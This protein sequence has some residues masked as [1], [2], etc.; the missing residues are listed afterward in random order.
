M[1]A[2]WKAAV[3]AT[4][5][6]LAAVAGGGAARAAEVVFSGVS[7]TSDDYQLGVVWSGIAKAAGIP[8]TVVENGTVA[9]MRKTAQGE[10]DMVGVGAPHYLDAV[11]GTGSYKD[12]PPALRAGYK[13]MR[14][15]LA[16][17]V[18]MAQYVAPAD[19]GIR[20][21]ADLKGKRVGIGRPGGNAGKVTEVLF[22]VHGFAGGVDARA[23]EYGPALE[24]IA[25]GTMDATLVWGSIPNATVDNASRQQALRFVSPDPATLPA[26][27][28]AISNGDYYVYKKVPAAAIA[29]AYEGRVAADGDAWFWTFPYQIMVRGDMDEDTVY[30]LT[31]ALWENVAKVHAASAAL[32]LVTLDE[33]LTA[34]S[35]ELHPGAARFYREI[36]KL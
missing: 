16:L 6:G 1:K 26:F 3:L 34:I 32:S 5:M 31:K 22:G 23:I 21:F 15:V 13:G 17:P 11:N 10:V 28:K 12:D 29:K 14:A 8:M 36:G 19:S 9:G 7:P 4:A 27:R 30:R 35:A 20:T 18:G 24:Q 2:F 25:A 33:A